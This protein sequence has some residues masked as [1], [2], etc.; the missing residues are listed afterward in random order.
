MTDNRATKKKIKEAIIVEGRDDTAAVKRAVEAVTVE[1]HGFG[2]PETMWAVIDKAYRS[3]GIIVFTDPDY[4]GEKIRE[5]LQ[6]K[7]PDCKAGLSAPGKALKKGVS[8]WK[9]LR[10]RISRSFVKRKM[11]T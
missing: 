5:R 2:M 7:Y 10:R 6:Q 3:Q 8:V 1:T 11:H 9:M 4:A